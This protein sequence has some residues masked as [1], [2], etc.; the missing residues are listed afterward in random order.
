MVVVQVGSP[1]PPSAATGGETCTG[2]SEAELPPLPS[3]GPAVDGVPTPLP[4]EHVAVTVGAQVKPSPQSA[5]ALQGN[6]HL[7]A[8]RET[9][10]SVQLLV[11]DGGRAH[12][13]PLGHAGAVPPL[14]E[15]T[16]SVWHTMPAPPQSESVAHGAGAQALDTASGAAT[17]APPV[18]GQSGP[19][20]PGFAAGTALT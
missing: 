16:V 1:L 11:D 19:A 20:Q 9:F 3:V 10:V 12:F 15:L 5:S 2:A 13:S 7:Y 18:L 14:H 4:P 17:S 6:C 8:Q